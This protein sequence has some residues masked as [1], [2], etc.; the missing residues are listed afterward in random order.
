M[1]ELFEAVRSV[2]A[3]G[4]FMSATCTESLSHTALIGCASLSYT[5]HSPVKVSALASQA[6]PVTSYLISAR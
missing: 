3:E 2:T 1:T 6:E 4:A 5:S